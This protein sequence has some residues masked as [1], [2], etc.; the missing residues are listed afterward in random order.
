[1]YQMRKQ[2]E[3]TWSTT[4]P[5]QVPWEMFSYKAKEL[6]RANLNGNT[7]GSNPC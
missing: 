2:H 1:M 7:G 4:I 3:L 5:T 6:V